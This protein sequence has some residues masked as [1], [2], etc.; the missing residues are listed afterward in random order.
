MLVYNGKLGTFATFAYN[1]S[2]TIVFPAG[3]ALNDPVCAFWQWTQDAAN[4]NKKI[5]VNEL[6]FISSVTT[7]NDEYKLTFTFDFYGFN[8]TVAGD[9]STIEVSL[10][11]PANN[12]SAATKLERQY[13]NLVQFRSTAVFTGK[14]NWF[15]YAENEML[16]LVI[17]RGVSNGAPVGLYHQWTVDASGVE[18]AN[19]AVNSTFRDVKTDADGETKGTFGDGYYTYKV[20]LR[21]NGK[22]V[23]I[24]MSN[25]SHAETKNELKKV[26][27]Y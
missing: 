22:E 12:Q 9:A 11:N 19:N 3:F 14:L 5:N 6:G 8:V 27:G 4:R 1:E 18:K 23:E 25:P 2:I 24:V 21:S 7:K 10:F 13:N 26:Y 16:T 17:P 15:K 20:T